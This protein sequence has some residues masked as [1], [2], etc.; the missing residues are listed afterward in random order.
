ME[1]P[2]DGEGVNWFAEVV[3]EGEEEDE[4][5]GVGAESLLASTQ[6]LG[7]STAHR[8]L[9]FTQSKEGA[10]K[11]GVACREISAPWC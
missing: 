10:I 8:E 11:T 7:I 2:S 6:W 9:I 4:G 5:G 3:G 1:T